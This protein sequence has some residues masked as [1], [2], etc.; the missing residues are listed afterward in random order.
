MVFPTAAPSTTTRLIQPGVTQSHPSRA[1]HQL[2]GSLLAS[3][4]RVLRD[5]ARLKT[6]V[7]PLHGALAGIQQLH[8]VRYEFKPGLGPD[9]EQVGF[10]TQEVERVYPQLVCTDPATGTKSVS[11]A[12]LT[13]VLLE[14]LKELQLRL[15]QQAKLQQQ[16]AASLAELHQQLNQLQA[17]QQQST[18]TLTKSYR[19]NLR[20]Q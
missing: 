9:G 1:P 15:A 16:T 18:N 19:V 20:Y 13:P 14:A 5:D 12:Q 4:S 8:G 11:Y 10:L 6:H 3:G 17:N 7:R 2:A